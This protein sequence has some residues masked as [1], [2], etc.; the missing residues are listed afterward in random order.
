MNQTTFAVK[1][2]I[3]DAVVTLVQNNRILASVKS[4]L[5]GTATLSFNPVTSPDPLTLC[6]RK[7]NYKP[8]L[9]TIPVVGAGGMNL[10]CSVTDLQDSNFDDKI[11]MSEKASWKL[12]IRNTGEID[13]NGVKLSL[14]CLNP[15][16]SLQDTLIAIEELKTAESFDAEFR[17]SIRSDCPEGEKIVMN[18]TIDALPEYRTVY[19][20][21][22]TVESGLPA[23]ALTPSY[24]AVR[25][26]ALNDSGQITLRLE[27]Q[28]Y[29]K[30]VYRIQDAAKGFVT[31]GDTAQKTW[32]DI[33]AG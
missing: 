8:L 5:S 26:S 4:D 11:S 9:K 1:V 22:F 20:L 24:F 14:D 10:V 21:T 17:F 2:G 29:G 27:N 16:V 18:L 23:I 25:A 13:A 30:L 12:N 32:H 28:G 33:P 3:S 31:V 7:E 6:V 19:P 15:Y